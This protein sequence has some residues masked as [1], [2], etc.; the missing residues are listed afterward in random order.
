VCLSSSCGAKKR[1]ATDKHEAAQQQRQAS[2][3]GSFAIG[4]I[5]SVSIFFLSSNQFTSNNIN[6]P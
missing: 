5:S 6:S 1:Q 3:F 4:C 2:P